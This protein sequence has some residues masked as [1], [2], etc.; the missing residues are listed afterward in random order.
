MHP[1]DKNKGELKRFDF[2][3]RE[4]DKVMQTRNN[5]TLGWVAGAREGEGVFNGEI[6]YITGVAP[7]GGLTVR[8]DDGK[9][10]EYEGES[11]SDLEL[12]YA[13][14]VHKS[15]GSEYTA[16]VIPIIDASPYL[17]YRN[18]LYTAV[19]RAKKLLILVGSREKILHMAANNRKNKRYSLLLKLLSN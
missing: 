18:L 6:G 15:Q 5:Y 2:V 7:A 13:V 12:A 19:T 17:L 4:G 3:F 11:L 10:T 16:V 9:V 14:T 8:F 1:P